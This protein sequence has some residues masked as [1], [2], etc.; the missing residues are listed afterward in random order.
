MSL[1][2]EYKNEA[3]Q[4]ISRIVFPKEDVE[5]TEVD[6]FLNSNKLNGKEGKLR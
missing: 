3:E 1:F 4:L 5:L 6:E 2:Q